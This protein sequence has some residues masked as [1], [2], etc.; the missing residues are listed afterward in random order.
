M[1]LSVWKSNFNIRIV[2]VKTKLFTAFLWLSFVII[3]KH[4]PVLPGRCFLCN[5]LKWKGLIYPFCLGG[6]RGRSR[7]DSCKGMRKMYEKAVCYI[8]SKNRD[9]SYGRNRLRFSQSVRR[10]NACLIQTKKA[11][12]LTSQ[13][14]RCLWLN[15]IPKITFRQ[16]KKRCRSTF[17]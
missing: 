13:R 5:K 15:F 11:L 7:R 14:L 4:R 3:R 17:R 8:S 16:G 12:W 9:F 2:A 6:K 1:N 10:P